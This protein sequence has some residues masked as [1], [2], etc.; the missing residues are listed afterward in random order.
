MNVDEAKLQK[1]KQFN[2][3]RDQFENEHKEQSIDS[4]LKKGINNINDEFQVKMSLYL[5]KDH[6]KA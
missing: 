4:S 6:L 1:Q 2:L 5:K 3:I